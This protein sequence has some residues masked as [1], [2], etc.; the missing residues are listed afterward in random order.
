L[1]DAKAR[2]EVGVA[3]E[4]GREAPASG[5]VFHRHKFFEKAAMFFEIGACEIKKPVL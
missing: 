3:S 4:S 2:L 1:T 5:C